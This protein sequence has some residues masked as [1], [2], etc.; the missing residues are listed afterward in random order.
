M[1]LQKHEAHQSL[2]RIEAKFEAEMARLNTLKERDETE[3]SKEREEMTQCLQSLRKML[4]SGYETW[5][6][7]VKNAIERVEMV[8]REMAER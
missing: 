6:Q 2:A 7:R 5:R 1:F 3:I 8:K 4:D